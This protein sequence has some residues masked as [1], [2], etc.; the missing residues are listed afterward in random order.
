MY[1]K[2]KL[3]NFVTFTVRTATDPPRAAPTPTLVILMVYELVTHVAAGLV[4]QTHVSQQRPK[5]A[6]SVFLSTEA[7]PHNS[8]PHAPGH[9]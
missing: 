2:L 8:A 6:L 7:A 1:R 3:L 5:D 9:T 4:T